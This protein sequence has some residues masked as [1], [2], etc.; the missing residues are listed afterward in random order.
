[1]EKYYN[2][3]QGVC[4]LKR[5]N[6]PI[7]IIHRIR[8]FS[9][10]SVDL[11]GYTKL[12]L[13]RCLTSE[14]RIM[15]SILKTKH[16]SEIIRLIYNYKIHLE[17]RKYKVGFYRFREICECFTKD[18]YI[19]QNSITFNNDIVLNLSLMC[20]NGLLKNEI[21]HNYYITYLPI[22]NRRSK[23][24]L[25]CYRSYG[26]R[27]ANNRLFYIQIDIWEYIF[28]VIHQNLETHKR[29]Y[30]KLNDIQKNI[31]FQLLRKHNITKEQSL[32][33]KFYSDCM[34]SGLEFINLSLIMN[35]VI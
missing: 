20:K 30:D 21:H 29:F 6:L 11:S 35:N 16:R 12:E 1:M 4:I 24:T 19:E 28:M 33:K 3:I 23:A 32:S 9:N 5:L 7:E 15:Y 17:P 22:K 13:I 14:H 25:S 34:N 27:F 18:F 31:Y 8:Y 10:F 2:S 26:K